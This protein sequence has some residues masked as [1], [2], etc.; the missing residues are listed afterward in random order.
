MISEK[1]TLR[2]VVKCYAISTGYLFMLTILGA[3]AVAIY[4]YFYP[5]D[6]LSERY[7]L[8]AALV[9]TIFGAID[10]GLLVLTKPTPTI[11]FVLIILAPIL[12]IYKLFK[13][14]ELVK[15]DRDMPVRVKKYVPPSP[16][17]S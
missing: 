2:G 15:I 6:V 17:F 12:A 10:L 3:L 7:I 5:V 9:F 16:V 1:M 4:G 14:A 8:T 13:D 11:I